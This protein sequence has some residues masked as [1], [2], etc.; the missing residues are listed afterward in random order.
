MVIQ[1]LG[2]II[3][4]V[5][6]AGIIMALMVWK[7]KREGKAEEANYRTFFVVGTIV[8]CASIVLM[9]ISFILQI[10]F[11]IVTPVLALGLIYLMIGL[12]NRDKWKKTV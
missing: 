10:F 4:I 11:V 5:I 8:V 6:A 3:A 9:A 7:K 2:V 12:A 1:I